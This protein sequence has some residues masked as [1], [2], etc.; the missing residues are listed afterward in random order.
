MQDVKFYFDPRCPWCYQTSKWAKRLESMGE[1]SLD[2]GVFCLQ[3]LNAE[4]GTDPR[5][6][7]AGSP[8]LRTAIQIER[9]LGSK[10]IGP[11]YTEL[12][13]RTFELT[14]PRSEDDVEIIR[15]ALDA[16]GLDPGIAD[17]ALADASTWTEVVD[18]TVRLHEAVGDVGVP[19]IVL[20]GGEGPAIFGPVIVEQPSDEG[21]GRALA[22]H[23]MADST[24]ELRRVE[25]Q[26]TV[27]DPT[28]RSWST[29]RDRG[30]VELSLACRRRCGHARRRR[31]GASEHRRRVPLRAAAQSL[32]T[33]AKAVPPGRTI[34]D[35]PRRG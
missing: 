34:P 15:E 3:V 35:M 32:P 8:Q 23:G 7:E 1:V 10:A 20:D 33:G 30:G 2:W 4:E 6:I 5:E 24:R 31:A 28:C 18:E 21:R 19:T 22:S 26:A 17:R 25:A 29:G 13:N 12:G 14:E 16:A 27:A 9:E 11:F